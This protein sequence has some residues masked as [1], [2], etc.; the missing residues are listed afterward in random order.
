M[1]VSC[2][3]TGCEKTWSRDPCL[4][5]DCPQCG[6][7]VGQRCRRPSG[8]SGP[9]VEYH[10]DRDLLALKEGAY[11][12]CPLGECPDSLAELSLDEAFEPISTDPGSSQ[13]RQSNLDAF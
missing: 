3:K 2:R 13:T 8:W 9:F 5:V 6:A 12:V 4:E 7:V 10:R 1:S 11:G